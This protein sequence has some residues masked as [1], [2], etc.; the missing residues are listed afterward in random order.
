MFLECQI[1]VHENVWD[2]ISLI[3]KS[4]YEVTITIPTFNTVHSHYLHSCVLR[5][6]T[7]PE[8]ANTEPLLLLEIQG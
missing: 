8:L 5:V 4:S 6:A 2:I 7:N 1:Q 3:L